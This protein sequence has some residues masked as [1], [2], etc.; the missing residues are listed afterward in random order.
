MKN[1]TE[2][3][4]GNERAAMIRDALAQCFKAGEAANVA[5]VKQKLP[6]D[7]WFDYDSGKDLDDMEAFREIQSVFQTLPKPAPDEP[8]PMVERVAPRA[9]I[10]D[11]P[12]GQGKLAPVEAEAFPAH[13][14]PSEKI[15][16][17]LAE[18]SPNVEPQQVTQKTADHAAS[19]PGNVSQARL[20]E[21]RK[22]EGDLLAE[23]PA[24]QR[25]ERDLRDELQNAKI[26]FAQIDTRRQTPAELSR[27]FREQSQL[28][29]A[30][31]KR[32]EAWATPPERRPG[33]ERAYV[34][35]ERA[36]SQGGDGN[37][38]ARRMMQTGN[39]RGAYSKQSLGQINRD[40]SRG[41]VPKPVEQPKPTIPA[42]AK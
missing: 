3:E 37:T 8:P 15:A 9:M 36:Y 23:R 38:F 30:A 14:P 25:A 11:R 1:E 26:A 7:F 41:A 18:L 5:N 6:D 39:R 4:N 17:P 33:G 28:Q 13:L 29:R 21:L 12:D 31:R 27:Q 35:I 10:E 20:D 22:I 24:L 40:P 34:D 32:G 42:L 16:E 19:G 2:T